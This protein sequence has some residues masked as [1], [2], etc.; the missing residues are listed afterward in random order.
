MSEFWGSDWKDLDLL[1]ENFDEALS[2]RG[3]EL[4]L[5]DAGDDNTWFKIEERK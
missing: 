5:G 1:L 4:T 3:L 2:V